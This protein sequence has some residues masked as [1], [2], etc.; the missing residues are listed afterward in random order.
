MTK[1]E[2]RIKACKKMFNG[3]P[4]YEIIVSLTFPDEEIIEAISDWLYDIR[5]REV[6][7]YG[8]D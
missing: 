4:K 6:K 3:E 5:E 8:N 1:M 2:L 7:R